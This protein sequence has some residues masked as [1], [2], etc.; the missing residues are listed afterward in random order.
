MNDSP[1][2]SPIPEI[3]ITFPEEEDE[4]GKRKSGRVVVVSVSDMGSVGLE[5][6]HKEKEGLPAYE[7]GD[8]KELDLEQ[9]G[10]LK[11]L[12]RRS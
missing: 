9:M 10:G 11:E 12:E 1:P 5:P 4:M 8:W 7:G 3:R 6:L 2:T